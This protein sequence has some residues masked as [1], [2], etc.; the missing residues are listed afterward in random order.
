M[1]LGIATGEYERLSPAGWVMMVGCITMVFSLLCFC[2]Y[3]LLRD[4]D[5]ADQHPP[6]VDS[7]SNQVG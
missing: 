2:Y 3:R 5:T 1:I 6:P 7:D 4:P